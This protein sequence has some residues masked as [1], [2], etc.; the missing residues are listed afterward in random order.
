[1]GPSSPQRCTPLSDALGEFVE[2]TPYEHVHPRGYLDSISARHPL[3][4]VG[5]VPGARR[6]GIPT[7]IGKSRIRDSPTG[8][9]PPG[10][11]LPPAPELWVNGE[12]AWR[13]EKSDSIPLSSSSLCSSIEAPSKITRR[14]RAEQIAST[15]AK[16][17]KP[18]LSTEV[19]S[20]TSTVTAFP[21]VWAAAIAR[22]SYCATVE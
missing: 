16:R 6:G 2:R 13:Y 4:R 12:T 11:P 14:C 9:N 7:G 8:P 5:T 17:P 10:H 3:L 19:R 1:M 15:S 21:S 22:L 18:A 20:V